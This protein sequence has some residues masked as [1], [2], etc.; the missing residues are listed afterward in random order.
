MIFLPFV[1][2]IF[3]HRSSVSS[4]NLISVKTLLSRF[5]KVMVGAALLSVLFFIIAG[6][7]P[8]ATKKKIKLGAVENVVLL[9][10]GVLMPARID[11]GAAVSSLDARNLKIK[12]KIVEF[13][14]PQTYGGRKIIL[15][16]SKW[17]TVK[18]A[19]ARDRRPVV[20]IELCIGSK[21][22]RTHVN[23]ND[24]SNVKYPLLLGRNTLAH[25]FL[26]ECSS[27]YCT[28]PACPEVI[29]R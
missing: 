6:D 11:T 15:P 10:W 9:P 5:T 18:S 17:K 24:R 29:L 16:I 8:S 23:L 12:G 28:E 25:N 13:N 21:R 14:L 27:S 2:K 4:V 22:I 1:K 20:V 3:Q 26:I 19:E 7:A